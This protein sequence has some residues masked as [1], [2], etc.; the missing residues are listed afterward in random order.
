MPLPM[1]FF[2]KKSFC[3]RTYKLVRSEVRANLFFT[4]ISVT[5]YL[6]K[7]VK[8]LVPFATLV[9]VSVNVFPLDLSENP[10]LSK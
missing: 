8:N 4:Q 1:Y 5:L 10:L 6:L 7:L 9:E 3:R 2:V